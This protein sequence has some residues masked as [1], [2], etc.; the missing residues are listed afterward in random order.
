MIQ[1]GTVISSRYEIEEKIGTGGM[2]MV[3]KATDIKLGRHVAVK[4]L[5]DEYSYDD[6]FV[7]KFK[8]EAQAAASLSH[9]NIVNIY[10][11][12]NDG[13]VYYIVME[14]LDGMT[15]KEYIRSHGKLSNE[16]TMR[17]AAAMASAL[18]CAH[19]NHIIHRDIKPQNIMMT[20]DGR[21]T[22]TDFGIARIATGA[23]IPATDMASGSVHYIPP[24][25]AKNG[26]SNEQSD[27]YSLGITMYEMITGKVPF[28]SDSAVSVALKQIHDDLPVISNHNAEVDKNLEQII[29]KATMKKPEQR[30]RSAEQL[31]T[32][33]NRANHSSEEA[34]VE[35]A[36][37][38]ADAHTVV[39]NK[40]QMRQIWSETEVLEDQNPK[41]NRIAIIGGISAAVIVTAILVG[42]IFTQFRDNIVPQRVAVPE[43]I[44]MDIEEATT[45]LLD[46]GLG[47]PQ[48]TEQRYDD[49]Y[50]KDTIIDQSPAA[51]Q[52]VGENAVISTVVSLGKELYTTPG[53][54]NLSYRVAE[55]LIRSSNLIPVIEH[56]YDDFAPI[57]AVIG[58]YPE[59]GFMLEAGDEVTIFV[60]LG[61]EDKYVIVPDVRGLPYEEAAANLRV[62][63]L[64]VGSNLTES[65]NNVVEEGNV[66]ALTVLPGSEV[67]EGYVIDMTISLGKE[68]KEVTKYIKVNNIL[69]RGESTVTLKVVLLRNGVKEEIYSGL[70]GHS[71]FDPA[72]QIPVS[73][74]G[75]VK[76][77][78][79]KDDNLEYTHKIVFTEESAE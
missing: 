11:V 6:E 32:D 77:E 46:I 8:V 26:Y 37:V 70:V 29:R 72:L 14:Y 64:K 54:S 41:A 57:G 50:P 53:V 47:S 1:V 48:V 78:V 35:I 39:M 74:V 52:I 45:L 63:G 3:Y 21:A 59:K 23:T 16:E 25:Q 24:E 79:Y 75:E 44:G 22:V 68:I 55:E 18:E 7:G 60:S 38:D 49:T 5:K 4:V 13:K 66:I 65:Y 40:D 31:L 15:L 9:S 42:F 10:D 12:G 27:I 43:I 69:D 61:K 34:F 76:Y 56:E 17:I 2:S 51:E 73:G 33:L 28:E 58:Q 62:A 36:A 20:K 30:Y 19:N 71:D 67:K